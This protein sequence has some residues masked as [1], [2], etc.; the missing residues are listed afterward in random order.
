MF[1]AKRN[2]N[3]GPTGTL[4]VMFDVKRSIF[5]FEQ[6]TLVLMAESVMDVGAVRGA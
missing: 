1:A 6:S 5:S 4:N 3:K 2:D